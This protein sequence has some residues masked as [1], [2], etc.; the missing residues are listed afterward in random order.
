[1]TK[2]I[3]KLT[4]TILGLDDVLDYLNS[5]SEIKNIEYETKLS[6]MI[7][8]LNY[9]LRLINKEYFTLSASENLVTDSEGNIDYK[10]L[11]H[12]PVRILDVKNEL[13]LDKLNLERPNATYKVFYNYVLDPITSI[14]EDV[15]LPIGLDY[16]TVSYGVASEWAITNL[17]YDEANMLN[18][19]FLNMLETNKSQVGERRFK[20]RRL[21]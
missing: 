21:K 3:I 5:E 20:A 15:T 14:D 11:G 16:A 13:L 19:K 6:K 8:L 2:E 18:S 7:V 10:L 1:M 4:L 17:M 9:V 12:T